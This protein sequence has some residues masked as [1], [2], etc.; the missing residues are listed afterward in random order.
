[1]ASKEI[2]NEREI[3]YDKDKGKYVFTH[4]IVSELDQSNVN[5]V[6]D[7]ANNTINTSKELLNN[8]DDT[9]KKSK[10]YI[11]NKLKDTKKEYKEFLDG[12]TEEKKQEMAKEYID[13]LINERKDFVE[14]F[15][16]KKDYALKTIEDKIIKQK[17]I[18][19]TELENAKKTI[20]LWNK[21]Y[22]KEDKE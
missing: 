20:K 4:T 22:K 5:A 7:D 16:D 3:E 1:M 19:K 14:N 15:G 6:V 13:K 9:L 10:E 12:L 17:Q 2:K 11:K 21:H 18:Y 8:F